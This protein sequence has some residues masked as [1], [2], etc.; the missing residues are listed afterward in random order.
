ML[1][2]EKNQTHYHTDDLNTLIQDWHRHLTNLGVSPHHLAEVHALRY[3]R[4]AEGAYVARLV[5]GWQTMMVSR[6]ST[7]VKSDPLLAMGTLCSDQPIMPEGMLKAVLRAVCGNTWKMREIQTVLTGR[8]TSMDAEMQVFLTDRKVRVIKR[9][10]EHKRP[11]RTKEQ[12]IERLQ[13]LYGE[14]GVL[15]G[16]RW[17]YASGHRAPT[18]RW[19]DK[20]AE[21]RKFYDRELTARSRFERKLNDLGVQ[22]E[23]YQTYAEYLRMIADELD[24]KG[25]VK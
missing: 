2:P 13:E 19:A 12:K 17:A 6:P 16:P 7:I 21:A 5:R 11:P 1:T 20:V 25:G 3:V 10:A 14:G 22:V 18:Y 24:E 23:P 8:Q 15:S 9:K 4:L